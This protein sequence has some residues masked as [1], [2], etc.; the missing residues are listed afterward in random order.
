ME[1]TFTLVLP[2]MLFALSAFNIAMGQKVN[3]NGIV[4]SK[5]YAVSSFDKIHLSGVFNTVLKQGSYESVVITTDENLQL[6]LKP[7][8]KSSTLSI[9]QS[10]GVSINNPTKMKIEITL[11]DINQLSNSGVGNIS[12]SGTLN[13]SELGIDNSGVGNL[14]LEIE[15]NQLNI[16]ASSVGNIELEGSARESK[17]MLTGVGN[18]DA[19]DMKITNLKIEN[20]GV[21]NAKVYVT[22]EIQPTLNGAG[23]ITCYG[24][25]SVK[26]L[27]E[28]GVGK[29]R[30]K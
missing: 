2:V 3:G 12:T 21:G 6:Y 19:E 9:E 27:N 26:N 24:N 5:T 30:K 29:F 13:L 16:D 23:N 8:V 20:S 18:I 7:V 14:D 1:K 11:K 28:E 15:T 17:I 25:P 22:G 10:E 4:T